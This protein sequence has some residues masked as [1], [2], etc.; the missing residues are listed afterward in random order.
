MHQRIYGIC[1]HVSERGARPASK[2]RDK[3]TQRYNAPHG[4]APALVKRQPFT[5]AGLM[6]SDL[7]ARIRPHPPEAGFS[8]ETPPIAAYIAAW[9]DGRSRD[10]V[11][12]E[13]RG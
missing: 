12:T 6:S 5:M 3:G 2:R 4:F 8:V 13:C 10:R 1:F 11:R 9:E 7:C